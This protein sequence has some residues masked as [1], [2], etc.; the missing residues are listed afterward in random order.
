MFKLLSP[1]TSPQTCDLAVIGDN[2]RQSVA[3]RNVFKF[4]FEIS[5]T[6]I[7]PPQLFVTGR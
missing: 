4:D 6:S 2:A 3:R 5:R 1:L 7:N